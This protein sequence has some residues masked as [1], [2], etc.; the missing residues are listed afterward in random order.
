MSTFLSDTLADILKSST[1]FESSVF[2]FPSQRAKVFMK[3]LLKKKMSSGFLPEMITVEKLIEDIS[4]LQL[5]DTIQLLFHFYATYKDIE[6]EEA[7]SFDRFSS[8]AFTVIQDFNEVDQYL[9]NTNDLY[10][11]LRDIQRLK[12]WSVKGEFKETELIKDHFIFMERLGKYYTSFHEFLKS[13]KIGYQGLL[14]REAVK[15]TDRFLEKT[16]SSSFYFIGFNALNKAE[17]L[18]FQKFL[19][20]SAAHIY[21]DI[22]Q[23]FLDSSHSAGAFIRKYKRE[24]AYYEK[25]ELKSV[26]NHF[27]QPKKIEVLGGSKNI[28]QL[29]YAGQILNSFDNYESTALVLGDESLLPVALSSIPEKVNSVNITMGYPL[30]SIPISNVITSFFQLFL[31]QERYLKT[32]HNQFYY[33][34][35][36]RFLNDPF[37][38]KTYTET[39]EPI[40][41]YL[42]KRNKSFVSLEDLN[43][44]FSELDEETH[45]LFIAIFQPYVTIEGFLDRI[46]SFFEKIRDHIQT[47]E[48]EYL[49]R[50]H[51]AF[52]QLKNLQQEFS[53]FSDLKTLYLFYQRVVSSEKL[54]FQGEPLQGLQLMGMLETRALDFE[55][56][57]ITSVNEQ[58]IPSSSSQNSFIPFD[59]KIQFGL[60]TYKEK[61]A[62]FSYHFFRLLQRAKN[63]YLLYNT[64]NDG[65]GGGEKSR[66]ISQLEFMKDDLHFKFISTSVQTEKR[67][68]QEIQK[69][70]AIVEKLKEIAQKGVSPSTI[71]NYLY[72]PILFYKQRILGIYEADIVEETVAANTLG[73]IIHDTLDELYGNFLNEVLTVDHFDTMEKQSKR[74]VQK[75]FQKHFKNGE[76]ETGKNRLI[77]EVANRYIQRFLRMEKEDVRKGNDLKIIATERS[78]ESSLKI[79][80]VDFPIKIKGI[81]DRIDEYNGV[82]RIIDYKTGFVTSSDL[83]LTDFSTIQDFKYSKA[84][85]ILLYSLLY[86]DQ[87][88]YHKSIEAGIYSFK[89]LK[90]GLLKINFSANYRKPDFEI[91]QEKLADAIDEIKGILEEI[92]A[93][94]IPFSE[95]LELP[96]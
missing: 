89:N 72:N 78:L 80:N 88:K 48:K 42:S 39:L 93:T 61:D 69:N 26:S 37:V 75:F 52:T 50:F 81:V 63:V 41:S 46:L 7:D 27:S 16:N 54:F 31:N 71:T 84:I 77:F 25:N 90:K 24:W 87:E 45:E 36:I 6:K 53:Y 57:I 34:D 18:I 44:Y 38:H 85:Q 2:V 82:R 58:I 43:A 51:S 74:I 12:K 10:T 68:L 56:L 70:T 17:E 67:E 9:V 49:Y 1:S 55:N 92:Y 20:N 91:T 94:D 13:K 62:I 28:V 66:F 96:F 23:A 3:G 65:Y 76:L 59:V 22:D 32:D 73:T 40:E 30:Q 79:K 8:W 19:M 47:L 15:N 14:Y 5:V 11:Y 83:K 86:T 4:E 64:E 95:P 21:W 29:K 60:P 35:V 33:K